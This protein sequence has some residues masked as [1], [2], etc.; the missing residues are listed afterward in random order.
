MPGPPTALVWAPSVF[1]VV[2]GHQPINVN[3]RATSA[4]FLFSRDHLPEDPSISPYLRLFIVGAAEA[5][6]VDKL[7]RRR[8]ISL[9][10]DNHLKPIPPPIPPPT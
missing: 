1:T 8:R 9:Q 2:L 5:A 10:R 3:L 7:I 4:R 6:N